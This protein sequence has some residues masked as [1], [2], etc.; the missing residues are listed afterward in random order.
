ML[1]NFKWHLRWFCVTH[2]VILN[3]ILYALYESIEKKRQ[4]NNIQFVERIQNDIED[5]VIREAKLISSVTYQVKWRSCNW[6]FVMVLLLT[7]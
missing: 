7:S 5:D 2:D 4:L 6:P 3:V 1:L